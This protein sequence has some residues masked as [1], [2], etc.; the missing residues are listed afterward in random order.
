MSSGCDAG[1]GAAEAE[2]AKEE[3]PTPQPEILAL[4]HIQD[5]RDT[6]YMLYDR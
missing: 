6:T 2:P 5:Q 3:K 4:K 1:H